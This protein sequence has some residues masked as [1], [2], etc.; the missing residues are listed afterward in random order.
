MSGICDYCDV[1]PRHPCTSEKE[2]SHCGNCQYQG[3]YLDFNSEEVIKWLH[4]RI[5]H[6]DE[7]LAAINTLERLL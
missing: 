4:H 5:G 7:G 6:V 1:N 3:Q 2:A